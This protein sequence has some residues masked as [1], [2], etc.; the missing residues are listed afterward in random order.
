[1]TD[2]APVPLVWLITGSSSGFGK[3]LVES[4]LARGD[5]IIATSRSLGSLTH[6]AS[7]SNVAIRELDV[8]AGSGAIT[9]IVA[10]AAKIWGRLDVVV[11]NAGAGFPSLLEE[12]GSDM[13]RKHMD[14]NF[15]G[16]MDVLTAA[17]PHLRAQKAGTVVIIG[18]RSAWK[19]DI[20]GLAVYGASKAAVHALAEGLTAESRPGAFRTNVARYGLHVEQSIPDYDQL[21]AVSQTRFGTLQGTEPG[22]PAKAME[23]VVDIV[24]GEGSAAGRPWPGRIA[25][26][27]DCERDVRAKIEKE[28]KMLDEWKDVVRSTSL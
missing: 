22:D 14:I 20:P 28:L 19:P 1:M 3:C 21:R 23:V 11:N 27:E 16:T 17:L 2:V 15:F 18:S 4:A 8:T 26:G 10:E 25:L 12:G 6:F 24:R 5:R 9:S 7:N 13:L